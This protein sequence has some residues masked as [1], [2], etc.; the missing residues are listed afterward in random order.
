MSVKGVDSLVLK[1][2]DG[3]THVPGLLGAGV[4]VTVV[5]RQQVNVVED[6]TLVRV[7]LYRLEGTDV[8]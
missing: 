8:H 5:L 4:Q 6:E 2:I 1:A 7:Q 3:D